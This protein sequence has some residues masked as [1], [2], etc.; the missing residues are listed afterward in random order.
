MMS[1][2]AKTEKRIEILAAVLLAITTVVVYVAHRYIPFMMDDL[3]YST[4]LYEETPI[5]SVSDILKSQVWHYQNW[6]GRSVAHTI[7]QLILLTGEQ[8]ADVLNVL[9]TFV[10]AYTVCMVTKSKKTFTLFAVIGMMFGLN[11]NWKMSMFWESGAANYLYMTIFLML[12]AYCYLREISDESSDSKMDVPAKGLL[13]ITVWIVPLGILAGW[14]NENMGPSLWVLSVMVMFLLWKEKRKIPVWMYLGSLA[15]LMG[16]VMMILAPG[17]AVRS[18]QIKEGEFGTLWQIFLRCYGECKA[19]LEFLFPVVLILLLLIIIKKAVL[20]KEI[21]R[22]TLLVIGVAA[23]SFGAMILSPHYPD[24]ATFGT[25]M[26]LI[27]ACIMT[28]KDILKERSDLRWPL[29]GGAVFV[30]LRGMY[31]CCEYISIYW[32]WI[33]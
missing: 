11:A 33:Q 14:S 15:C 21:G 20:R 19:L 32:G 12:Y 30:W 4:L 1:V 8:T 26:F 23:L 16:S 24:R 31:F 2:E 22:R 7:L 17:N 25:M 27:A 6:G 29:F 9:A 5:Q 3:W 10:L 18:E 28:A 13:G